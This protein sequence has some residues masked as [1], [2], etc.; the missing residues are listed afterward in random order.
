M[1]VGEKIMKYLLDEKEYLDLLERAHGKANFN[2]VDEVID[3]IGGTNACANHLDMSIT[4][5]SQWRARKSIP[6][7][8]F[9]SV[10]SVASKLGIPMTTMDLINA[11]KA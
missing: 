1:Q 10:L 8:Q 4:A 9:T 11:N 3:A 6:P 2:T 5:I 7:F